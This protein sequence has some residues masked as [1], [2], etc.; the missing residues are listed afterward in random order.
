MK[1]LVDTNI[2]LDVLLARSNFIEESRKV[3]QWCEDHPGS[4]WIAWHTLSN[5]SFLGNKLV[6]REKTERAIDYVISNFDVAPVGTETARRA[7]AYGFADF[8]DA[9]QTACAET[10]RAKWIVTRNTADF[11]KSPIQTITP[12]K[13]VDTL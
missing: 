5:L 2:F 4:G 1:V 9:L 12:K 11:R 7:Q 3:L 6:G 8:E 10:A 13:F